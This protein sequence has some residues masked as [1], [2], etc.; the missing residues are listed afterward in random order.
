ML[1]WKTPLHPQPSPYRPRLPTAPHSKLVHLGLYWYL[2]LSPHFPGSC[3][4]AHCLEIL[5][6]TPPP[7][8]GAEERTPWSFSLS[9]TVQS[10]E[11]NEEWEA[12]GV[13]TEVMEGTLAGKWELEGHQLGY[14]LPGS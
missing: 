12:E 7:G 6:G 13:G 9:L 8:G 3:T 5:K 1:Y 4:P 10:P 2:S 11:Q 14:H